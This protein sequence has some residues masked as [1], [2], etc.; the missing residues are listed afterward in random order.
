[1]NV[2]HH[3]PCADRIA[4]MARCKSLM[5]TGGRLFLFEHNPLNPVTRRIFE[6]CPFDQGA[7][8]LRRREALVLAEAVGLSVI[9]SEYTLFFPR[10]LRL[11]RPFERLLG[12]FPLGAQ[13]CV[14]MTRELRLHSRTAAAE[15]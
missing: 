13:Y 4:V 14:E 7:T 6:R 12:W 2:F 8:M 5:R 11:L 1:A 15:C 10:Q 3:I 9:R